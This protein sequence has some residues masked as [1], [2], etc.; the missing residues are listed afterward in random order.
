MVSLLVKLQ[1]LKKSLLKK[2]LLLAKMQPDFLRESLSP[3]LSCLFGM[4][5]MRLFSTI[6]RHQN[7]GDWATSGEELD[8]S[9]LQEHPTACS[10]TLW[11]DSRSNRVKATNTLSEQWASVK[12]FTFLLLC[13]RANLVNSI[14]LKLQVKP[15]VFLR[16]ILTKQSLTPSLDQVSN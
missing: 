9:I 4:S 2:N 8:G 3:K 7:G 11:F 5:W 6:R 12:R 14:S 15:L 13:I 1:I 16:K 10:P